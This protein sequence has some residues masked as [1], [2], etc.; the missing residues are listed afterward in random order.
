MKFKL[1]FAA[2]LLFFSTQISNAQK[3]L[4][5]SGRYVFGNDVEN[6][7][8]GELLIIQKSIDSLLIYISVSKAAPSYS[9]TSLLTEL[10]L[11][12]L[13]SK[14]LSEKLN[15]CSIVF[16]F[17]DNKVTT[18]EN[19]PCGAAHLNRTFTRVSH[20]SPK[21]FYLGNGEEV[22]LTRNAAYFSKNYYQQNKAF[23]W[24]IGTCDYTGL[25]KNSELKTDQLEEVLE[26]I[27]IYESER[28]KVFSYQNHI[29]KNKTTQEFI[30]HLEFY[31]SNLKNNFLKLELSNKSENWKRFIRENITSIDMKLNVQKTLIKSYNNPK[32]LLDSELYRF[33]KT[34]A[35]VLNS[36]DINIKAYFLKFFKNKNKSNSIASMKKIIFQEHIEKTLYKTFTSRYE[37][38]TGL[39]DTITEE[40]NDGPY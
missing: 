29:N 19:T 16:Q 2:I 7:D 1:F 33:V 40:C 18:F 38:F 36:N 35:E 9:T 3:S 5:L 34:A 14:Y 4:D 28:Q 30:E 10:T 12:D 26:L 39:F 13:T 37:I 15:E 8:V 20:T 31:Y 32:Y 23:S 17:Q 22:P 6:H 21:F 24:N 27:D 11:A 25:F